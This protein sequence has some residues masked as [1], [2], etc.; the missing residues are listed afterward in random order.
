MEKVVIIGANSF[1]NPLILKAKEMGYETHVFAWKSGDIGE[2]TADVFYPVSIIE[3]EQIL[4]ICRKINPVAVVSIGS[5]LAMTTVNYV[6]ERLGLPCNDEVCVRNTT[7]K[8]AMRQCFLEHGI[9]VPGFAKVTVA[10]AREKTEGFTYPLIVKPTDRSG[11][12][13]ITMV[14]KP[15][16]LKD[17][18]Q[19]AV[20]DAFEHKAIVE[21]YID[22]EEYSCEAISYK[23]RHQVL[24]MTK[25]YT[26]GAPHYIEIGHMEPSGLEPELEQRA[27]RE[28]LKALEALGIENGA[29]HSEFRIDQNGKI[30]II[31]IGARM[32]GDCIG[33]DLVQ[34]STGYDFVRMVL[35][36]GLGKEPDFTKVRE[37]KTAV[38][39][40][41]MNEADIE[42]MEKIKEIYGKNICYISPIET[43]RHP[44][45]DSSSRYGYYILELDDKKQA[46]EILEYDKG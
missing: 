44:V 20:D 15:E 34:I 41:L 42:R 28:I 25:K 8:A 31:E 5:D 29:S 36:T 46:K 27:E 39:R 18:V 32:G 45:I 9:F 24:A 38:I 33:S 26:T 1:Q 11:S 14:Q 37:P 10:D 17:A 35:E 3:K 23:G 22:G 40:F 12:R 4:E 30:G 13:S 21:E 43:E 19:R 7:N 6:A 2:K 16:E